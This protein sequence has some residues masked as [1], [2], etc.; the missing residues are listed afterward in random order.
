MITRIEDKN[1]N[2]IESFIPQTR[3]VMDEKTAYKM[4][5]MLM[6]GV[7]EAGGTSGSIEPFLKL[8][9]E[10]GGKTGTTDNSSDGW[11]MGVTHNLV[12]GVWVGGDEPSIHFPS[13]VFG[14]GG[15]TARPIW[16]RFMMKVYSDPSLGYGKG[17][18][19]MPADD[20]DMTLDCSK[21]EPDLIVN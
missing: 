9:N 21:Y 4:L 5:Y 10:L 13:W 1:G 2:V 17:K 18:F 11:Y 3:Q 19:K 15:R 6:G 20:L 8:D 12:T 7:E 14:S 16:E